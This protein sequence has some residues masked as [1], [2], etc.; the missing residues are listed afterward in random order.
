MKI[1]LVKGLLSSKSFGKLYRPAQS[2]KIM[3]KAFEIEEL[4]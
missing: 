2:S 3:I 4:W 1:F